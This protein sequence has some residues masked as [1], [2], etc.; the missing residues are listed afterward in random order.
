[1]TLADA[2]MYPG[3]LH[4]AGDHWHLVVARRK[5]GVSA[6]AAQ[7]EMDVVGARIAR[8]NPMEVS[9]ATWGA[10]ASPLNDSRVDPALRRSVLDPLRGA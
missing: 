10:S 5:A 9:G 3:I 4:E 1:M 8:D 2:Y 6:A 7:A